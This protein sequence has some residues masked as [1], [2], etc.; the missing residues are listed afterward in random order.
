MLPSLFVLLCLWITK[1]SV[2]ALSINASCVCW[3]FLRYDGVEF[4]RLF[5]MTLIFD[6]DESLLSY[7]TTS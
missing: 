6:Y 5:F 3:E 4:P 2:Q 7:D 1:W